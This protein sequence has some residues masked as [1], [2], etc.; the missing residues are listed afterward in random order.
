MERQIGKQ[1]K[2]VQV[3]SF[4]RF[5]PSVQS[6]QICLLREHPQFP[7]NG[8]CDTGCS[9]ILNAFLRKKKPGLPF[10]IQVKILIPFD[11]SFF[12]IQ[13]IKVLTF[14]SSSSFMVLSFSHNSRYGVF[15]SSSGAKNSAG[16]ISKYEMILNS[17][18]RDG[19]AAPLVIP[20][21]YEPLLSKSKAYLL[22]KE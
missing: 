19:K 18:L 20:R 1:C 4:S 9:F 16:V 15:A 3:H 13:P 12:S 11:Y 6:S 8:I 10:G 5:S 22:I 2:P 21:M 14:S 7:L 17:S